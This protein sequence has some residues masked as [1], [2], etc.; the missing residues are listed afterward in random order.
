MQMDIQVRFGSIA[1]HSFCS[2]SNKPHS[3][4]SSCFP[5]RPLCTRKDSQQPQQNGDNSKVISEHATMMHC[6]KRQKLTGTVA[7]LVLMLRKIMWKLE[8]GCGGTHVSQLV[9]K[10][11]DF[12]IIM[13]KNRKLKWGAKGILK[14]SRNTP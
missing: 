5:L 12:F 4:S 8:C 9:G 6:T 1:S 10:S 3:S 11:F 13:S 7:R 14:S 2:K